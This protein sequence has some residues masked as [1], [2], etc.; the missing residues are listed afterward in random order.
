M[1]K[2][3]IAVASAAALALT[4]LVGIAP[5]NATAASIAY[6][7]TGGD[8]SIATPY[9]AAVPSANSISS[10]VNALRITVS[11]LVAGDTVTV[12]SA[13]SAK[14]VGDEIGAS[15][16]IKVTSFGSASLTDTVAGSATDSVFYVYDTQVANASTL[17][18]AIKETNS[19]VVATS[20][21]T[22]YFKATVGPAHQL[23]DL[24]VADTVAASTVLSAT[25]K[26]KDVFGNEIGS[27]GSTIATVLAG[28]TPVNSG[29]A[30]YDTTRKVYQV[31][32][33]SPANTDPFIITLTGGSAVADNGL[34][35]SS[36]VAIK[37]MNSP[38][39]ATANAT[40]TAQI[41]ALT[42]QLAASRPIATSV[43]KKK[44]NTLARKWNA[45]FPS[46]K[47][48]LKK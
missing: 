17:T 31:Q 34:G 9:T 48:A 23:T 12:S 43:T 36:L 6:A 18:I 2:K 46:Q 28:G 29:I 3:L 15:S 47:V 20:S 16:L 30:T 26:I 14:V 10:G 32:T 35:K 45:A 8:G 44:Y 21:T 22:K 27:S 42:A 37:I 19:G 38:A 13:G 7:A 39:T 24:T 25:F 40:A 5:A 11:G 4:A 33:T 1:S 41:A